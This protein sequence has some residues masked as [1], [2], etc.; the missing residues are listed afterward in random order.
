MLG[1]SFAE[2][3]DM[4]VEKSSNEI[5]ARVL[6]PEPNRPPEKR[7]V[8]EMVVKPASKPR[9]LKQEMFMETCPKYGFSESQCEK[10]WNQDGQTPLTPIAKGVKIDDIE[11]PLIEET[12]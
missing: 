9:D 1:S 6:A 3:G 2:I 8:I 4:I 5:V 10:I 11:T 7:E 12:E